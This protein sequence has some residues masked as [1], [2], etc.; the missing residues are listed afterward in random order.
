M[1]LRRTGALLLGL[2]AAK[3]EGD[4]R[5]GYEYPARARVVALRAVSVLGVCSAAA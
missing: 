2:V 5:K 4:R 1:G 3:Y